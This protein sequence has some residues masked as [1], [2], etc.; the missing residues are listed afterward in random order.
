MC[1]DAAALKDAAISGYARRTACPSCETPIST[2]TQVFSSP[3]AEDLQFEQHGQFPSGYNPY[4]IFFTYLKCRECGAHYCPLYYSAEQLRQLYERQPENMADA[5]L[6]SRKRTQAGYVEILQQ[7]SRM[8]GG[9]LEVGADIGLFAEACANAGQFDRLWLAE[10]NRRVHAQLERR[11]AGRNATILGAMSPTAEV[12]P[13]TISTVVMI[14]VLDHLPDPGSVLRDIF[15]TLE[16]GGVLMIVTHDVHSW[17][18]RLL[19]RRWPPF[20]LQHPQLFSPQAMRRLVTASGFEVLKIIRTINYFP[21]AF[22]LRAGL[23]VFGLPAKGIPGQWG[24]DI[25]VKLGNICTLARRSHRVT[26]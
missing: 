1:K 3:R 23:T 6:G 5:S 20:A 25:A 10:P 13:G 15:R 7:Y 16:P 26:G 17:L 21:A 8:A 22:L 12:P 14:H 24:P 19:G 11:F 18:A 4:R 2:V 9:L